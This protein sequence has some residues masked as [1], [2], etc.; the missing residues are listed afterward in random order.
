MGFWPQDVVLLGGGHPHVEVLRQFGMRPIP[1]V[2]FTLIAASSATPYRCTDSWRSFSITM[3]V[4]ARLW[5]TSGTWLTL[6][7]ARF[8]SG[9]LPGYVAGYYSYEECHV[10]LAKL[11]SFAGARLVIAT[12][13]GIDTQASLLPQC[14]ASWR[15]L[16]Q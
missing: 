2:R 8:H 1:G 7:C 11:T 15:L 9:M 6:D 3:A 4:L 5:T 10:D 16:T 13:T 12:A 14:S